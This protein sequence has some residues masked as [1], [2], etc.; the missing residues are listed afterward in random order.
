MKNS[1][2]DRTFLAN[3]AK[4]FGHVD[5]FTIITIGQSS[6]FHFV[7]SH[8]LHCLHQI[9]RIANRIHLCMNIVE[10][11]N[12][13]LKTASCFMFFFSLNA[14]DNRRIGFDC[15]N[16]KLQTSWIH[17]EVLNT[18]DIL[19]CIIY[20][21]LALL[22]VMCVHGNINIIIVVLISRV[23]LLSQDSTPNTKYRV[24]AASF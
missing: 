4:S 11:A 9:A 3:L 13:M 6:Q 5:S 23:Y 19:W 14:T 1:G 15:W 24:L 12:C 18:P 8:T 7:A 20:N 21:L 16:P 10:P 2:P 22:S 17:T